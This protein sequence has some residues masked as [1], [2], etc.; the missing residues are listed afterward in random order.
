MLFAIVIILALLLAA[1]VGVTLLSQHGMERALRGQYELPDSL[2][3]NINSFPYLV[4]LARNHLNE[5]RLTWEGE[6]DYQVEEGMLDSLHYSG[7]VSLYDVELNMPSLLTAR[8]E[9]RDISRLKA[10]ISLDISGLNE[11]LGIVD[12]TLIVEDGR[13]YVSLA[14]EKTQ[15][16]VKVTAQDS[17]TFE[18][19]GYSMPSTGSASNVNAWVKTLRIA[20]PPLGAELSNASVYGEDVVVE[21]SIPM[22]E[23]Y[24]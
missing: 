15:C 11:A 10:A 3:V 1:E 5:L 14:G 9:I 13:L 21:I 22:W 12:G 20:E 24:L 6:L 2:E 19:N 17:I 7:S 18:P 8:L 23:G 16:K 4:S